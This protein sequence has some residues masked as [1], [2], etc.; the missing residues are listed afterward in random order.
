MGALTC[1]KV[2]YVGRWGVGRR[3]AFYAPM[4]A[5]DHPN[6]SGDRRIAKLLMRAL[7]RAGWEVDL[8]SRLRS[9]QREG[10]SVS[11]DYL[12]QEADR[13]V[14]NLTETYQQD[15][16][17]AWFTYHCYY[18]APDLIGPGVARNLG[19]P[20]V[21]AEGYRAK[22][23]FDGPY[24]R[25]AVAAGKALDQAKIIYYLAD[26]GLDALER[27][28]PE[29]Q[30]L[31]HLPP[32]TALGDEPAAKTTN[33]PI[34]LVTV[35]MMRP[36]DKS[37]SYQVLAE[38]LAHVKT[39]WRLKVIGAGVSEDAVKAMFAQFGDKVEFA[40]MTQDRD[41]IRA[42]YETADL[43]IWPGV[44]E[45]FGMVYLEA[46]AAGTPCVAQNRPGVRTVIAPTGRMTDPDNPAAFGAAIDELAADRTAL[47]AAS[48]ATRDHLKAHHG[49]NAASAL[50]NKT[51]EAVT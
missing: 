41:I 34:K 7:D 47:A 24:K 43:F 39:D 20:Y 22:K 4:K 25:F 27:D 17:L 19:I 9:H 45:A 48:I 30:Q 28:R 40:G 31:V 33:G 35:A 26:R 29:G 32:F 1:W 5:P 18:K 6:P 2:C 10:N 12:F 50:L 15:T 38:A 13:I 21:V 42:A 8:A 14:E 37:M 3:V 51:L 11:Q 23:R 46:Q 44:N 36:G 16:P 49:V